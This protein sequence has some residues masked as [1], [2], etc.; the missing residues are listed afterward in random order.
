MNSGCLG[1]RSTLRSAQCDGKAAHPGDSAD[2]NVASVNHIDVGIVRV[3]LT[4]REGDDVSRLCVAALCQKGGGHH[5]QHYIE[6]HE[7]QRTQQPVPIAPFIGDIGG[8]E[9]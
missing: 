6:Q 5:P 4:A 8:G 9:M 7:P 1:G 3:G 2:G